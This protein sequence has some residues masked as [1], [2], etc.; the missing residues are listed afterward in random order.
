MGGQPNIYIYRVGNKIIV[1]FYIW[2]EMCYNL[3][4]KWPQIIVKN[5]YGIFF[6]LF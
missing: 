5:N 1:S 2:V 3:F 4:Y 6:V